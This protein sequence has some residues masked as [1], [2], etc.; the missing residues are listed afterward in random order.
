MTSSIWP[1][2]LGFLALIALGS[3]QTWTTCSPTLRQCPADAGLTSPTYFVDF[4]R[5]ATDQWKSI[6]TGDVTYS[7]SGAA[8]T[9]SRK[10]QSPTLET[11]WYF[12]FGRAEVHMRAAPGT[13]IV[14]CIVLESDDLDEIDWEWLGGSPNEV[15]TNYFGKGNT[16]TY[17]RGGKSGVI[18]TQGATHNYTIDWTPAAITWYIDSVVV[19][20]LAYTDAVGGKNFPQTPM[21]LKLG[22]WAGGDPDNANGTI[23][24][25]G[26]VTDY[27]KGPFTMVVESV[28]VTNANPAKSY[29]YSDFSGD[30][31]SIVKNSYYAT[32]SRAKGLAGDEVGIGSSL[33]EGFKLGSGSD[34]DN[35]PLLEN[36]VSRG[37]SNVVRGSGCPWII[38]VIWLPVGVVL[39]PF[40]F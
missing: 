2:F 10:G 4:T 3:C 22:I 24:W 38:C 35:A 28:T 23:A 11:A 16:T 14:S 32:S 1:S 39:L 5:G 36:M 40:F 26:G 8:F 12:F 20:T 9:I 30:W 13:G 25:A 27:G 18:N 37:I 21:R 34:T 7:S 6:G 33:Y 17:D 15:Q 31:T 19:R 29:S